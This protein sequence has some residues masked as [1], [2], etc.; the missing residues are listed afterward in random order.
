MDSLK[1]ML[2]YPK[3][4]AMSVPMEIW[5]LPDYEGLPEKP[6]IRLF[7]GA[8]DINY[9]EIYEYDIVLFRGYKY[10]VEYDTINLKWCLV[11]PRKKDG[12]TL[13]GVYTGGVDGQDIKRCEIIGNL[14]ENPEL[15]EEKK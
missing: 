3:H 12:N 10:I 14:L 15:I 1:V 8:T 11:Q 4:K 5:N 7:S 13:E 9:K 6:I 2:W